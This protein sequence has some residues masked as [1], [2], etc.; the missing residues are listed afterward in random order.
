[1]IFLMGVTDSFS[2]IRAQILLMEPLPYINKAFALVS[3]EEEQH[4]INISAST[5]PIALV[6]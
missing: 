5:A 1:M 2:Q 6:V 4:S 3:L